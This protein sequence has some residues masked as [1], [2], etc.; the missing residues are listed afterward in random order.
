MKKLLLSFLSALICCM[1][2]APQ[3]QATSSVDTQEWNYYL[4]YHNATKCVAVGNVVYAVMNGNLMAYNSEEGTTHTIDKMNGL[5][6]VGIA[7]IGWDDA[8]KCLVTVYDNNNIDLIY[9]D[10]GTGASGLFEVVNMPDVKNYTGATITKRSLTVSSNWACLVTNAGVVVID[11]KRQSIRGYYQISTDLY[12]AVAH[13]NRIY[14][15]RSNDIITA[16]ILNSPFDLSQWTVLKPNVK[17][18]CFVSSKAGPYL[19]ATYTTGENSGLA[20]IADADTDHPSVNFFSPYG[21]TMGTANGNKVVFATSGHLLTISTDKPEKPIA[22]YLTNSNP[23]GVAITESGLFCLAEGYTGLTFYNAP[24]ENEATVDAPCLTAGRFG[25]RHSQSYGLYNHGGYIYVTGGEFDNVSQPGFIGCYD[26]NSWSDVDEDNATNTPSGNGRYSRFQNITSLAFDPNDATHFYA[27]SFGE[28]LY[29]YRDNKFAELYNSSNSNLKINI[30]T[31]YPNS[32]IFMGDCRFDADGN[33][34]GTCNI[35]DSVFTVRRPDGSWHM[36][37]NRGTSMPTRVQH[38]VFDTKGRIWC[39]VPTWGAGP[40]TGILAFNYNGTLL[41]QSDD[42]AIFRSSAQ[43]EDGT[44]CSLTG[45]RFITTDLDGTL[46]LGCETGIYAITDPD[47]WF[48]SS[49]AQVYQP[50]VPRNDGT[51]YADYLLTGSTVS[52]M[53]VDGGNRKWLGTLGGGIYLVSPDGTEVIKHFD[54][55]NSPILSNNIYSLLTDSVNGRLYIATDKGLCSYEAGTT[56]ALPKL[57]K[58]NVNI[59]PNPV[60]VE[61]SGNLNV[62]GLTSGAEV[63]VLSTGGQLVARGNAIGGSWQW[64]LH[65]MGSGARVATGVYF[66]MVATADGKTSVAGKFV[67]I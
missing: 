52:A 10:D 5:S 55:S 65:H 56:A 60:R 58:N 67:V 24:T 7:F 66:I 50:K 32:Y 14:A 8:Q 30:S 37:L 29:E 64:N 12:Y 31:P 38:M 15:S 18:G 59:F 46:W 48:G 13:G 19:T 6:D 9:P 41:D 53:A 45:P 28:G 40:S 3:A 63:K 4:S 11:V 43:N 21:M 51:N 44:A 36:L 39:N 62:T 57:E 33:L 42:R 54:Q 47:S 23:Y 1:F 27:A 17:V 49:T 26:G 34:W 35:T 22:H 25:P 61:F 20:H 2:A 16:N